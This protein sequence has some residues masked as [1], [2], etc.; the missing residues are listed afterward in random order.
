MRS[1]Q[2]DQLGRYLV[3]PRRDGLR[4]PVYGLPHRVPVGP[5]ARRRRFRELAVRTRSAQELLAA[6]LQR[7]I[8]AC[9]AGNWVLALADPLPMFPGEHLV[10]IV[11]HVLLDG[12]R[13]AGVTSATV[14]ARRLPDSVRAA[15]RRGESTLAELLERA[16]D[17]WAAEVLRVEQLRA[18]D[19]RREIDCAG[20]IPVVRVTRRLTLLTTPVALV[21]DEVPMPDLTVHIGLGPGGTRSPPG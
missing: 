17:F 13:P 15:A 21:V 8:T 18:A 19:A 12:S 11:E 10:R 9:P 1:V 6:T 20:D 3:R 7:P 2:D 4:G 14:A 16:G 5:H